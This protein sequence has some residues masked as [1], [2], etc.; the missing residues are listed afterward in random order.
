M[1]CKKL[2][3]KEVFDSII[4]LQLPPNTERLIYWVMIQI[5]KKT[6]EKELIY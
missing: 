6:M 4:S 3:I 1:I 2:K 5:M